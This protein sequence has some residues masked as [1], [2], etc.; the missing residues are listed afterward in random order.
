MKKILNTFTV[1]F[2]GVFNVAVAMA[3]A[4]EKKLLP[5][6]GYVDGVNPKV[7]PTGDLQYE[8]LP[9]II[10]IFLGVSGAITTGVFVYVGI[11]LLT[12]LGNEDAITK[13]KKSFIFSAVGLAL[14]ITAYGIVYG[15]LN[16]QF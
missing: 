8:I 5:E 15:I 7:L 6:A 2:A 13:F 11:M 3:Q 12:H 14:I 16:L 1:L 4:K 9:R 10:K